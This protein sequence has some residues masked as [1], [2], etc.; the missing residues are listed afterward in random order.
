MTAPTKRSRFA[1]LRVRVTL[2]MLALAA[3]GSSIFAAS[4]FVAAERLEQTVL[5]RHVRAEFDTL[6]NRARHDPSVT[7]VKS[8]LLLGFVGR[9][10]PELPAAFATLSD[11]RHHAV[12]VGDKAYQV[13]VGSDHG[14]ELY[15]DASSCVP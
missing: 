1:S 11:G 12:K 4:V 14:R 15:A 3:V 9:D 13:Y 2:A 6:A 10:N 8:A 7:T 5:D